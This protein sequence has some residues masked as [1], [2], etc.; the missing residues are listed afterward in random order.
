[1]IPFAIGRPFAINYVDPAQINQER[2]L[3][4]DRMITAGWHGDAI[5]DNGNEQSGWRMTCY[6]QLL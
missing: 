3:L 2:V 4:I 5:T 1:M 6:G